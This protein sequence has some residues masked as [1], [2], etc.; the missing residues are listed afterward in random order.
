MPFSSIFGRFGSGSGS[1]IPLAEY[2]IDREFIELAR[3]LIDETIPSPNATWHL[4]SNQTASVT[5]EPWNV[6][7][8]QEV[9]YPVKI[10]FDKDTRATTFQRYRIPDTFLNTGLFIGFMYRTTFDPS[11]KDTLSWNGKVYNVEYLD[12]IQVVKDVIVYIVGV[13]G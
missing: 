6:V 4:T 2:P 3:E 11:L 12:P 13:R 1:A 8:P 7:R 10:L 9:S 5:G